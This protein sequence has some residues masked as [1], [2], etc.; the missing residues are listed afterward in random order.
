MRYHFKAYPM[1][2]SEF[3][4]LRD[5]AALGMLGF[6]R[7]GDL[8]TG[9]AEEAAL[10]RLAAQGIVLQA[11]EADAEE[12]DAGGDAAPDTMAMR[13]VDRELAG[14]TPEP[15]MPFW[16]A[17]TLAPVTASLAAR[18]AEAGARILERD[19]SGSLVLHAPDGAAALRRL[20]FLRHLR[21]YGPAKTLAPAA[22]LAEAAEI[23]GA[24]L[25][26]LHREPAA[27]PPEAGGG[28]GAGRFEAICHEAGSLAQVAAQIGDL[29]G[30]VTL[31]AGRILRF[32]MNR[33]D[34]GLVAALPGVAS[35]SEERM[36]RPRCDRARA[37]IGLD[38]AGI[39]L[40]ALPYDGA[41]EMIG[42]ADTGLDQSHPDFGDGRV[43][44]VALG[45]PGDGSDPDGHGTHVAGTILGDGSASRPV[46][47]AAGDPAPLRGVA[48]AARLYFQSVLDVNGELGG[49]PP[50]LTDLLQPAHDAGVRIH[51]NSWGAYVQSRYDGMAL[52][53]D[54][55]VHAH[56]DF[57]PVIAAGNEGSCR[58]H[59]ASAPGFVDYPS[60]G[61]PATAK[62]ALTVGA[63]RSDR[64]RGGNAAM[65]WN[66]LWPRDF[67]ADP[68][69][70]Q[71]VSGDAQALAAFSSRGPCDSFRIKPDLVAPGTDIAAP[72]AATAPLSHF[73]GAYPNNRHY[74]FMG[75]T[76]MATPVVA[77]CAALVRQ[78]FR[79]TA[80]HAEPSAALIKAA[81]IN[82][83]TRLQ[84]DDATAPPQGQPNY[85]QG[86]GRL[87]MARTLPDAAAPA[88]ELF[89][90]DTWRRDQT[91]RITTGTERRRWE[92]NVRAPCEL[93]IAL[94]WTDVPARALENLFRMILDRRLDGRTVNWVANADAVQPLAFPAHDPRA[95]LPA[96]PGLLLR[97]PHNNVQVIRADLQPGAHTLAIFAEALR[98]PQDF[99][100]VASFPPGCIG[101]QP[102]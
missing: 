32:V 78:Y 70:S 17:D 45:R 61:S 97:D 2:E 84:G 100:L 87:D 98:P 36:P 77:G 31:Q 38:R 24:G 14:A 94:V 52:Q 43:T 63:S 57:L 4:A 102:R 22:V 76:S 34:I 37:I 21:P 92:F 89:F 68:I 74:A 19:P 39:P 8:V 3:T 99:A 101:I 86:F 7:D 40:P 75:G 83:T 5:E 27:E 33:A 54:E 69:A 85:H 44:V 26:E 73:W 95:S 59:L 66:A 56:P 48:P 25:R 64:D 49:L 62:N 23:G 65:T 20:P 41:G 50:S 79:T 9:I 12:P 1:H 10:L 60:L 53:I 35:L 11:G 15:E 29:G 18:L 96:Q 82:G 91:L 16:L 81:L 28:S 55:F 47:A 71:K 13:P 6:D 30:S 72:R 46:G 67:D 58:P 88:F 42:V 93:R 51:N 80:G 90:I